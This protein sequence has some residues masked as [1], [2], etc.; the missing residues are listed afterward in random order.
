MV[1]YRRELVKARN[2]HTAKRPPSPGRTARRHV[3]A[4]S[5][6]L[7]AEPGRRALVDVGLTAPGASALK[8]MGRLTG[9][10]TRKLLVASAGAER[11][12]GLI[13]ALVGWAGGCR[14]TG[15]RQLAPDRLDL[16][17]SGFFAPDSL[18]SA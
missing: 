2:P 17:R 4:I 3:N 13:W 7:D 10:E 1:C 16:E 8:G 14:L 9:S 18:I 11:L 15:Y 6:V 12:N 5:P